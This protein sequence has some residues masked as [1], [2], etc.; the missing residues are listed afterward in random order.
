MTRPFGRAAV[1]AGLCVAL[2]SGWCAAPAWAH[3]SLASSTPAA[4]ARLDALPAQAVLTFTEDMSEPAYVVVTAPDGSRI[5]SGEPVVDGHAVRA[6]LSGADQEGTY[7]LAFRVVSK[8]G[9][10]VTGQLFFV[11]GDGPLEAA[12]SASAA[13]DD[14]A[15]SDTSRATAAGAGR[16]S[17]TD[18][19]FEL[20]L[21]QVQV[22]VAVL[23]FGG[24]GALFLLSLRRRT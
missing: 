17:S 19:G 4:N 10:P 8:D 3:A 18:G 21:A 9:H 14:D 2:L 22:L 12:P 13:P 15:G 1:L 7:A 23:L 5:D 6:E 24:A 20:G 11:V 16:Q